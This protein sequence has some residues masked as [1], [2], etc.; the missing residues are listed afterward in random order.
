VHVHAF[1]FTDTLVLDSATVIIWLAILI[2]LGHRL[3]GTAAL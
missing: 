1:T 3:P 2:W